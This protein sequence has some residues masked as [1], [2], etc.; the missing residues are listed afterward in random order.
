MHGIRPVNFQKLNSL[1]LINLQIIT[2]ETKVTQNTSFDGIF[3]S[4]AN[5]HTSEIKISKN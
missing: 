3:Y 4:T 5:Y 2:F 1:S